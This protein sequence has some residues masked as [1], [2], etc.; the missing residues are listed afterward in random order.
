MFTIVGNIVTSILGGLLM[1]VVA[2][3]ILLFVIH[4]LFPRYLASETAFSL[5]I[6][7]ILFIL[8]GVQSFLGCGA[9][10]VKKYVDL[11]N[12][13][14]QNLIESVRQITCQ[15][16][17][18][19]E[20][21]AMLKEEYPFVEESLISEYLEELNMEQLQE[22]PESIVLGIKAQLSSYIIRRWIWG[23]VFWLLAATVL[24]YRAYQDQ[25]RLD[26]LRY[27]N[28]MNM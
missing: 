23:V 26:C 20:I 7:F 9:C 6:G 13:K 8:I 17:E 27:R 1:S 11:S 25:K 3:A 24:G 4:L 12:Q 18:K 2:V 21:Q 5:I 28:M 15:V 19:S 22:K 10:S 14:V 16:C